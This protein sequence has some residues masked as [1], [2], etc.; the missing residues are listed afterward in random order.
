METKT[1]GGIY[2]VSRSYFPINMLYFGVLFARIKNWA[3][4]M[5]CCAEL[6]MSQDLRFRILMFENRQ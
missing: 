6:I 5:D 3:C 4:F 2:A 1:G